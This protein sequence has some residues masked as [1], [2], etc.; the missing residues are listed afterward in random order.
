MVKNKYMYGIALF[1]I[2]SSSN[3]ALESSL[4]RSGLTPHFNSWL[5]KNNYANYNF[6]RE[7]LIGG[8][9]GGKESDKDQIKN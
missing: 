6:S 3:I 1:S 4:D 5:G 7:D 9:Y 8:S 2:L